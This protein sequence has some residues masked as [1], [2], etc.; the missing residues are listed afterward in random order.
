VNDPI[1]NLMG[2]VVVFGLVAGLFWPGRGLFWRWRKSRGGNERVRTEDGLKYLYF[3]EVEGSRP[4][5]QSV[6]GRLQI[7]E[8]QAV[9]L[10]Q[11][12]QASALVQLTG[13]D[14]QLTPAGRTYALHIVRAHR[15]WERYLADRTGYDERHWHAQAESFEHVLTAEAMG[16]LAGRLGYPLMD[17]HG[18]P[19]PTQRGELAGRRGQPLT[20]VPPGE[21]ARIVH[22]EDEPEAVYA[23]LVTE[24]FFPGMLVKVL[25]QSQQRVR[26][27]AQGDE[28]LLAPIVAAA[29]AVERLPHPDTVLA[30]AT[31]ADLHPPGR[32]CIRTISPRCRNI[33]RRRL[34]D[35]GFVPG[36]T[37]EAVLVSPS[38]DPTAYRIRDTLIA[39]R[40]EQASMV[41]IEHM[42]PAQ[43]DDGGF[44]GGEHA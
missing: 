11:G 25:D 12:M 31:L 29:V 35:L 4:T 21:T 38:G 2:F 22:L 14:L 23:Q 6:A 15:L 20:T 17:P 19:I 42:A 39:L 10:L 28:H 9:A 13:V 40:R 16:D 1:I 18:D 24:G 3:C 36:T 7:S 27:W 44:Q 34:L 8:N 30:S 32:G 37:V 41:D 5:I 26:V 33:E 43:T